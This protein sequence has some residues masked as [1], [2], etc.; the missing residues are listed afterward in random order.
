M[1]N[2]TLDGWSWTRALGSFPTSVF[3]G[4]LTFPHTECMIDESG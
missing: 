2:R 1:G 3:S 4:F